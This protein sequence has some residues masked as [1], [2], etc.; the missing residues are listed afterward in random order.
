MVLLI[1][2]SFFMSGCFLLPADII[3]HYWLSAMTINGNAY[4]Y[5]SLSDSELELEITATEFNRISYTN[6]AV[7]SI[8][9]NSYF[10]SGNQISI[11]NYTTGNI[12]TGAINFDGSILSIDE[13]ENDFQ[14]EYT[15]L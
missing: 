1:A 14:W 13:N 5:T 15:P 9:S 3:G 8:S 2:V 12:S 7:Y 11:S 10:L 6:N 4:T